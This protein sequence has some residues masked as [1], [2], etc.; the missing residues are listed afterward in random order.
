MKMLL[1]ILIFIISVNANNKLTGSI[2]TCK[3]ASGCID[4]LKFKSNHHITEYSCEQEYTYQGS[5]TILKDTL[6][7]TEKDDSHS[8]DHGKITYYKTRYIIVK[9]TLLP[10]YS[11]ELVKDKWKYN[12]MNSDVK[13]AYKRLN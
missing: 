6:T 10:I 2:W 9:N 13:N 5:Y 11:R 12:S 4:T 8:E 1:I 3:I 7:I